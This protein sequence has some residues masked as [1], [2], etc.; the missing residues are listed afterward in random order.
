MAGCPQ[1]WHRVWKPSLNPV[2]VMG[3][4]RVPVHKP[5]HLC[6]SSELSKLFKNQSS[7]SELMLTTGFTFM[8]CR[9]LGLNSRVSLTRSPLGL[10]ESH[11]ALTSCTGIIRGPYSL[12]LSLPGARRWGSTSFGQ[13]HEP[14]WV[15]FTGCSALKRKHLA[16]PLHGD[17]LS[18]AQAE[19]S[20][21]ALPGSSASGMEML[22]FPLKWPR[23]TEPFTADD[24]I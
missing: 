15:G 17:W 19:L 8:Y 10:Q 23:L 12:P 24:I 21:R 18:P 4:C 20:L 5:S 1:R 2:V 13:L 22:S 14:A 16:V 11:F 9:Q 7:C 3:L 6:S